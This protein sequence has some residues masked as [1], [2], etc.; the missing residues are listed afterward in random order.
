MPAE[1][2]RSATD[3][4]SRALAVAAADAA[5]DR[6]AVDVVGLDVAEVLGIC[7]WFVLASARNERQ[8]KAVVDAV[9]DLVRRRT[10]RSPRSV[11]G[12]EGR[13]WV[14][15]D[16]GDVVV[17]VFHAEERGYYRLERLYGD[18]PRLDWEPSQPAADGTA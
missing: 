17:H 1:H 9:E 4:E 10:G 5:D 12:L 6:L 18:V 7:D 11:E 3:E 2:R 15:M 8:V 13:R 14:L 16:Y